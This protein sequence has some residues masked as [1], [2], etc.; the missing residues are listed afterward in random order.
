[1]NNRELALQLL[2]ADSELAVIELLT[3]AGYWDDPTAWRLVGDK[4]SNF[5]IIGNQQSRPEA[6]L[7]EK[8]VNSV[9][10]RLMNECLVRGIDPETDAAPK[11]IPHA[12]AAFFD[13]K[14]PGTM[15]SI[16][17]WGT[18]KRLEQ[19]HSITVTITGNK[20]RE[21]MPC[22]TIADAGEG[23]SPARF[24]NTFLSIDKGNKLRIKFVQGKFNMGGT[25]ALKFCGESSLQLLISKRNP[26]IQ[27][28]WSGKSSKWTSVDDRSSEWGF[29][30]VRREL[31]TG[32]T[33]EVRN[34]VFRYL[35]PVQNKDGALND[36]LSF[37]A[38]S[39]PIF[40]DANRPY[41]REAKFGTAIKLYE[42]DVKGFG[43]HALLPDG[44]LMR[45]QALLPQIALPV[46]IHECR[47]FKGK[48]EA[49]FATNL[50]G[51]LVRLEEDK[52]G[53][54]EEGY[55]VTSSF[56]VRGERMSAQIY[57]F[58]GDKADSYRANEG[59]I[60]SINGQTHGSIPKTFF[61]RS[62]VKMGR[63][64]SALI[65]LIDCSEL[66]TR[67]RE[68]L[69]MNSRDRL[70][71]GELRK[72]IEEELEDMVGKHPALKELRERRR[73]EE[74]AD[75][76]QESKPLE[77]ILDSIIKSSPALERLFLFGQRLSRPNRADIGS[78]K[79]GGTGK[80]G[81]TTTFE[82]RTHP[83][84]FR[85]SGKK[86]GEALT[87]NAELDRRCRLKFET[88]V[89][90]DYF[91]RAKF[92]GS[93]EVEVVGGP[94]EGL[95][96]DN[97]LSLS[98]G[99]ANWSI[100]LPE[101]RLNAGDKL[102]LQCSVSDDTLIEPFV[103]VAT[104]TMLPHE[105]HASPKKKYGRKQNSSGGADADD[106]SGPSGD[107][108]TDRSE[109]NRSSG[110]IAL[111]DRIPVKRDDE[112]WKKYHFNDQTA[113]KVIE[114]AGEGDQSRFTFYINVDNIFLRTDMKEGE[115]NVALQ[116]TKFI[117]ANVLVGLA[118]IHAW[119][120]R[121]KDRNDLAGADDAGETLPDRVERTTRALAPFLIPMIDQLGGLSEADAVALAQR[122]DDD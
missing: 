112:F 88:D 119:K 80:D 86:N 87:R 95:V 93:Y 55:P 76:L 2:H 84:Y 73:S 107:G 65:I 30:V 43:S 81:G 35:A 39:L 20:P 22:I 115:G 28:T 41:A 99:I 44:L 63:L 52:A 117:W 98:D 7:V 25:G 33:G 59:I 23:Q 32:S 16:A 54:L 4:D 6:A 48:S 69:F 47:A 46:R 108:G 77:E 29:T 110:G 27:S 71:N 103:N 19:A 34:S 101:E 40:P 78:K 17:E 15:S 74:I 97:N 21:G 26:A 24:P 18:A 58:K 68:D 9:D 31:P 104:I 111:P 50:S 51:L 14:G 90:N 1:M 100:K 37:S 56:V 67:A 106:G 109:G 11:S 45:L 66:S 85:F 3:A 5:S 121:Q 10:A 122:G 96:L 70:S 49:S 102:T 36:V 92:R 62:R 89:Q 105:E 42:Y 53:N 57:A 91:E 13:E 61:E 79:G 72:E 64:A 116:Q 120:Q 38:D 75:R 114:D 82:G 8:I 94:L 83:T 12:I 60:F 118:L 113:C